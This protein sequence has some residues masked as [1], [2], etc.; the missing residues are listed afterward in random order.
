MTESKYKVIEIINSKEL[1]INYGINQG[2]KSGDKIRIIEK[3]EKIIDPD[4]N[5]NLGTLDIIKGELE[6]F[7]AYKK[8]SI[9][10]D[11]TYEERDL[12]NPIGVTRKRPIYNKLNVD[13]KDFTNRI[14]D[15]IPSIKVGDE[16]IV[17]WLTKKIKMIQ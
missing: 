4:T 10:R 2:A 1:I 12:F 14:P 11:I 8:F 3:G 6:V 15:T 16:V 9:C 7:Q 17:L 5:E 13:Q